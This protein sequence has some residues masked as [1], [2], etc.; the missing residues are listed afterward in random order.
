MCASKRQSWAE[1]RGFGRRTLLLVGLTGALFFGAR[2]AH[3]DSSEELVRRA[4]R[5]LRGKSS[6][7][8]LRMDIKTKSFSRS[9]KI[10]TWDDSSGATDKTLVKILG[11]TS[12]RGFATLKVG[13]QL[14]LYDPKTNHIQSV[15]HSLLGDSWMGSHFSNDDLVKETQLAVHYTIKLLDK[16]EGKNELGDTVTLH[17]LELSPKPT[18]PVVWGR[19]VYELWEKGDTVMPVRS[20]YYR[21]AEDTKPARSMRMSSVKQMGGRLV[22]SVLE[23]TVAS[24]PG[25]RTRITYEKLRFD[26]KIPAS[27]FTEQ[28]LR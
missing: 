8:V 1:N 22:P 4:D 12:W 17:R 20:D 21:K 6:A 3:A 25:E 5:V 18:A 9:Y 26:L 14:K 24:K 10:V 28:A 2:P 19:I 23:V 7:G 27:K 13:S 11:P 16:R 15:G